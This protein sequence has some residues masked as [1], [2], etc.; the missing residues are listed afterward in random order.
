[1]T[2]P[3]FPSRPPIRA[4]AAGPGS[5]LTASSDEAARPLLPGEFAPSPAPIGPGMGEALLWVAGFFFLEIGG[6]I[7]WQIGVLLF[8]VV[9]RGNSMPADSAAIQR[10]IS[11]SMSAVGPWMIGSIKLVETLVALIA[12]RLRFGPHAFH[13]MGFRRIPALHLLVLC[14]ALLPTAFL[15]GQS[16]ALFSQYWQRLIEVAPWLERL[17]GPTSIEA[18]QEMARTTPLAVLVLVIA[19]LPALNEEFVFRGAIGRGLLARYGLVAGIA[20]TSMIFAVVHLSPVHAAALIPLAVL[21]HVGYISSGSIWWPVGLHFLNNALSVALMKWATEEEKIA[22]MTADVTQANF[23]PLLFIAS[24]ACVAVAIWFLMAIRVR[25][26]LA[27]GR[28]WHPARETVEPPPPGIAA[29]PTVPAPPIVPLVVTIL[30]YAFYPVAVAFSIA[31][32]Q[33]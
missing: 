14:F 26:R 28:G 22:G 3:A 11:D 15:A 13:V 17:D 21:M 33:V 2:E 19:V 29:E 10:L 24:A 25:W 23:S 8:D 18:V 6:A 16:Y 12:I 9:V 20:L 32:S 7:A 1:M 31:F 27:D 30:C 4:E 5:T